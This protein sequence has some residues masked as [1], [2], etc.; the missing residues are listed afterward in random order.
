MN[1]EEFAEKLKKMSEL[2][3][4]KAMTI[5][6]ISQAVQS[7]LEYSSKGDIIIAA[8][9]MM[10]EQYKAFSSLKVAE[11]MAQLLPKDMDHVTARDLRDFALN[12]SK[13]ALT[14]VDLSEECE[15][16][17]RKARE[18]VGTLL[19]LVKGS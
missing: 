7:D 10:A 19:E 17:A 11:A 18:R 3:R 14:L 6:A 4:V 13:M 5:A 1:E 2:S 9:S 16:H 15:G 12:I 8:L